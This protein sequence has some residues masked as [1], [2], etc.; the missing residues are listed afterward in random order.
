VIHQYLDWINLETYA[1]AT[2]SSPV[3]NL[4]SPLYDPS[5]DAAPGGTRR[6]HANADTAVRG[7]LALGV[8]ASKLVLGAPFYGRGWQGVPNVNNG[9]YQ[10]D[11]GAATDGK[12]P[13][14]TW[15]DGAIFY[16]DL[17]KYYVGVYP[18]Y[19]QD[20]ANV[21]WLYSS[22]AKIMI[23]YEDPQSLGIKADYVRGSGLGGVMIW[24]LSA[25][26]AQHSLLNALHARLFP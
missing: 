6:S 12:V 18:R 14:N 3:T 1:Y 10:P 23:T 21:P 19:W 13:K 17:L 4:N 25:D 16:R 26:D 2:A 15:Q 24:H 22:T 20:E 9:L 5:A 11:T 8:P 7:Y